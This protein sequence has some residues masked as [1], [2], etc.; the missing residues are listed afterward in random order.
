MIVFANMIL[1]LKI[2]Q[3]LILELILEVYF[4]ISYGKWMLHTYLNLLDQD[5]VCFHRYFFRFCYGHCPNGRPLINEA[6]HLSLIKM[7]CFCAHLSIT[8]K[9]VVP[10]NP[11]DRRLCNEHMEL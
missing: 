10:Y 7:L 6:C 5:T 1:V 4:P 2:I 3:Y 8:N 9:T 11:Q